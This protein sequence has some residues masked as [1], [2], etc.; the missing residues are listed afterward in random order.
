LRAARRMGHR[1]VAVIL[2]RLA[3]EARSSSG[4]SK[5]SRGDD[6]YKLWSP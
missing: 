1:W 5:P 4:N 3:E 2:S 6:G